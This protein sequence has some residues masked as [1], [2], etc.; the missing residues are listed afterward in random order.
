MIF[1]ISLIIYILYALFQEKHMI[2]NYFMCKTIYFFIWDT[3]FLSCT[4]ALLHFAHSTVCYLLLILLLY[5]IIIQ[6]YI[7]YIIYIYI[8]IYYF[9]GNTLYIL[10]LLYR[11]SFIYSA[12]PL[13]IGYKIIYIIYIVIC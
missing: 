7:I 2:F 5:I 6:L 13:Y 4:L 11:S 12:H 1:I 8:Y 9:I 10:P 3:L